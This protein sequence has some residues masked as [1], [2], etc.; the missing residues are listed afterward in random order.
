M[1]KS[2]TGFGRSEIIENNKKI[3]VEIKSVNHRYLDVNLK[4]PKKLNSFDAAIRSFIKKEISRGKI[5]IYISY[6]D[7]SKNTASLKFNEELAREYL[8]Y[9]NK[10]EQLF[11]IN[12]DATVMSLAKSPEVLVM[13]EQNL[14]EEELW[15]VLEKALSLAV[16]KFVASRV[17]EGEHL[18]DDIIEKLSGLL[19]NVDIIE[20]SAPKIIE[21]YK[22]KLMDKMREFLE[23][24]QIDENRIAAEVVL[25]SDFLYFCL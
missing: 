2:M 14:D 7:M 6:E 3:C 24:T 15:N 23:N 8:S 16:E 11:G 12:N 10:M 1:I 25:F 5:D 13:E 17:V 21:D 20:Q 9:F 22:R 18:K 4:M 19:N